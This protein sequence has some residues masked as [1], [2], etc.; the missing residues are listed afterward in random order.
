MKGEKEQ[1]SLEMP[2]TCCRHK[3]EKENVEYK[4]FTNLLRCSCMNKL[5]RG[6]RPKVNNKITADTT[7]NTNLVN[8]NG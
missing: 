7:A 8:V 6:N 2:C 1:A 5:K 3:L 4:G